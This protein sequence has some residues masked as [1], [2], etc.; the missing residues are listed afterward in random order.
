MS[1]VLTKWIQGSL[2]PHGTTRL[3]RLHPISS[4]GG[5]SEKKPKSIWI[6]S[7]HEYTLNAKLYRSYEI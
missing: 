3:V 6:S 2:G 1:K 5:L 4:K 7:G